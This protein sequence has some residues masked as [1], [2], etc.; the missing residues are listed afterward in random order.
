MGVMSRPPRSSSWLPPIWVSL[1]TWVWLIGLF[2]CQGCHDD[3]ASACM[4]R[5]CETQVIVTG[6]DQR[7]VKVMCRLDLCVPNDPSVSIS[8]STTTSTTTTTTTTTTS[9]IDDSVISTTTPVNGVANGTDLDFGSKNKSS[10]E[11]DQINQ[12]ST[13]LDELCIMELSKAT[14]HL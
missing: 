9:T 14:R 7:R 8:T 3:S 13:T 10:L 2:G 5:N 6:E 4:R 12:Q 1:L 11:L